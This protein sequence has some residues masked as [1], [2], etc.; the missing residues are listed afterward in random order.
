M[1]DCELLINIYLTLFAKKENDYYVLFH[2]KK[3]L[4]LNINLI[5]IIIINI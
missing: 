4:N 2:L 1:L 5:N 3:Q